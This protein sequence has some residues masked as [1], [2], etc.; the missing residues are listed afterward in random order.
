MRTYGRTTIYADLSEK[1]LL[2]MPQEEQIRTIISLMPDVISL[3]E[4]NKMQTKYLWDYYLGLQ[5]VLWKTKQT[6][7]DINNKKVENWAYALVDF[8]KNWILGNPIQYTMQNSSTS[9]EVELL[10]KYCKYEDK[11]A[12]DQIVYEDV[13][14][15]GRGYKFTRQDE[16]TEDD[17]APFS[18]SNVKKDNCEVVY[19]SRLG[20]EQLF[21]F[22]ETEREETLYAKD[23]LG[24]EI[25][26]NHQYSQY[27]IYLRN[28][29][30]ILDYRSSNP[31]VVEGSIKPIVLNEH[32][33]TEYYVNRDRISLIELGKDLFDGINQMESLD[34]DDMQQFV[35]AIM[36]FTNAD[37]DEEGLQAVQQYGA[38][39]IKSTENRKASVE[40][41]QQRLNASD[42]QVFYTRLLTA[43]H[44]ILGIPMATDN[45]SVTSGD[46]GRAKMTGQGYTSSGIRAKGDETMLRMCDRKALKVILKICRNTNNSE[47]K[48]LKTSDI[49]IKFNIDKSEN[50]L[51]KTQGLMNLLNSN[52]PKEYAVPVVDL[53]G[54]S[55]AVVSAMNKEQEERDKKAQEIQNTVQN[56]P[57]TK[58]N[59]AVDNTNAQNNKITNA[60][61]ADTQAQ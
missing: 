47:I 16:I 41:L 61:N 37:I 29:T 49:D 7:T 39:K 42:T 52:I 13:L 8:K 25:P 19:S 24:N 48:S 21:S 58:Q 43:L 32:L 50:L 17:E 57:E 59:N 11:E 46:T 2:A 40:L 45:G 15:C 34:F 26:K 35:N 30:F 18:I 51:V 28:K 6:R 22:A 33:I 14:V 23:E 60:V 54:D 3:H 10:N 20:N 38:V 55:T 1:E 36:V 12:K 5:D 4:I 9:K 53:F 56:Y 27:T 31:V 44:Q